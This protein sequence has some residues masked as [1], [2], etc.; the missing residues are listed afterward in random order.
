VEVNGKP[1]AAV[2]ID[3]KDPFMSAV[4]MR[5]VDLTSYMSEGKNSVKVTYDGKL[6]APVLL[7][8][9]Q[10]GL[11]GQGDRGGVTLRRTAPETAALG[12]PVKVTLSVKAETAVPL[13]TVTDTVPSN[14]SADEDSLKKILESGSIASYAVEDDKVRI[15][16]TDVKGEVTVAY[17]LKGVRAGKA[18]HR[19]ARADVPTGQTATFTGGAITVTE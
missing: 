2:D 8:A 4:S 19:G 9:R 3:P 16:L 11:P 15:V 13:L 1:A 6:S 7:E 5:H 18:N 17:S 10:W 14:M 12:E